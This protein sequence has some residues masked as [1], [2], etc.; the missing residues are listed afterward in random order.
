MKTE[1]EIKLYRSYDC[2][3]ASLSCVFLKKS[4]LR[5]DYRKRAYNKKV[6]IELPFDGTEAR[7]A[8]WSRF[9]FFCFVFFLFALTKIA[10]SRMSRRWCEFVMW[11]NDAM[12]SQKTKLNV[13]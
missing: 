2:V 1:L 8:L 6:K 5:D 11:I 3:C 7:V 4:L 10:Q 13:F 9:F 12:K